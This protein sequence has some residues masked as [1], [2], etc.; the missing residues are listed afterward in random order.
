MEHAP[1]ARQA[2]SQQA[3]RAQRGAAAITAQYIHDLSNRHARGALL[4]PRRQI[5]RFASPATKAGARP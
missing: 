1:T 4:H 2:D 5:S 3:L